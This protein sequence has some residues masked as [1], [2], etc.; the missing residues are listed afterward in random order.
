MKHNFWIEIFNSYSTPILSKK[1][2]I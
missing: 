2:C 1:H